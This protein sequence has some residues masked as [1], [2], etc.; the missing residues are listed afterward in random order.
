[1]RTAVITGGSSGIGYAVAEILRGRGGWRL[2]LAARGEARLIEAAESLGAAWCRCDVTE[3]ADVAELAA[4][5]SE[6]GGCDLLVNCAGIPGFLN[7]LDADVDVY[8]R[9]MDTNFLGLV[10]VTQALWPQL[11]ERRGRDANVGSVAGTVAMARSGPYT[12]SK[13]AAVAYSRALSA[14]AHGVGVS[15]TTVNP[16]PVPTPGFPQT[17]L[18]RHP[19]ARHLTVDPERCAERL[20]QAV[21]RGV[22]EVFVPQWWRVVAAAQGVVPGLTSRIAGRVW[23]PQAEPMHF[24][25]YERASAG[26]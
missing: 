23:R 6:V 2:L 7:V 3:D 26:S 19:L 14:A 15:V 4:A 20:L 11:R 5:S 8:R 21:D 13:H 10:R 24:E 12:A 18:L 22:P 1:V 25:S 17:A 16:G 9:L